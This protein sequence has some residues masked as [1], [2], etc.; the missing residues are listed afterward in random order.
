[1]PD[2]R[3]RLIETAVRPLEDNAE[4]RLSAA[5]LLERLAKDDE[6]ADEAIKRW[7]T[8]DSRKGRLTWRSVLYTVLI[9]ASAAVLADGARILIHFENMISGMGGSH[10]VDFFHNSPKITEEE[11]A[12][13]LTTNQTRLLFGDFSNRPASERMKVLWDSEPENPAYFAEYVS[14]YMG[15]AGGKLPPDFLKTARRLDPE[16]AWFT[17]LAAAARAKDAVKQHPQSKAAK[18]ANATPEWDVLDPAALNDSLALLRD[19]R[20]QP[21]CE[22]YQNEL[23]RARVKLLPTDTPAEVT[24]ALGYRFGRSSAPEIALG[25]LASVM[26]AKAWLCGEEMNQASFKELLIDANGFIRKRMETEID[27]TLG[28]I[29]SQ[30]AAYGFLLNAAPAARKLGLAEESAQLEPLLEAWNGR[31]AEFQT[32]TSD[33]NS[34]LIRQHGGNLSSLI[35][36]PLSRRLRNPPLLTLK[37]LEPGRLMDHETL[38]W[39]ATYFVWAT[40]TVAMGVVAAFRFWS[41]ALI[42]RLAGRLELLILPRDWM[43]IIGFGIILPI[44]WFVAVTRFTSLGGRELNMERNDLSTFYFDDPPLG[45]AQQVGLAL[46]MIFS[47]GAASCW[48]LRMRTKSLGLVTAGSVS[49]IIPIACLAAFIPVCGWS[50]VHSSDAAAGTAWILAGIS[51]GWLALIAFQSLFGQVQT[52]LRHG[53]VARMLVPCC[54]FAAILALS[55][56]PFYKAMAFEWST[57]DTLVRTSENFPSGSEFEHRLALQ[58]R[59]ELRETLGYGIVEK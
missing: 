32:R 54:A 44:A 11:I 14:V 30:N 3:T 16:N 34:D 38:A 57:K 13:R 24:F 35:G 53:I 25:S 36:Y 12:S 20:N 59:K 29:M 21:K 22:T 31:K 18:A 58:L 41:P 51:L 43:R 6:I 15:V 1:M 48:R 52:R 56:A 8:V 47:C 2:A 9:L 33:P 49:L 28:V 5:G 37:D 27:S 26:A 4:M 17:Y 40:L 55:A 46:L 23:G 45:L 50:V 19:A 7:E 10:F 42:R 39:T